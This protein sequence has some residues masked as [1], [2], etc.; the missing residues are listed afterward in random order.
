[1][2]NIDKLEKA[3]CTGC[4][5]CYNICPVGAISLQDNIEGFR[6]PVINKEKC[7]NCGLCAKVCPVLNPKYENNK[8]PAC[9]AFMADDEIR[10][11]SSSGGAFI[12]LAYEFLNNGGYVAGAVWT[13]DY[14]VKHIVSNKKEDV[15][16]MRKSKYLQSDIGDCYTQIKSI[17][18]KDKKVLFTGTPCQV[19][20]LKS[21]LR[22]D[23]ENLFCVDLICHGVPSPKVFKKYIEEE[24][25]S[26]QDEKWISTDFRDKKYGWGSGFTTTTTTTTTIKTTVES[27][28]DNTFMKSF[29]A[30]VCLRKSCSSCVVSKIPR[31]GDITIGDLWTIKKDKKYR[32][33]YCDAKGTS[34]VLCNSKKGKLLVKTLSN[35]AKLLN[36]IPLKKAFLG[37]PNIKKPTIAHINREVFFTNIDNMRLDENVARNLEDKCDCM[38]LNFWSAVNYGAILTCYGI[39]CLLEKLGYYP[40]IINYIGYPKSVGC[41]DFEKSFSNKFAQK[42]FNLTKEVN[43]YEDFY[44]LN[45][46]CDTFITGSDQVWRKGCAQGVLNENLNWTLF[47]LDFVR[48]DKKKLSYAASIGTNNIDGT[49]SDYE[50][51]NYYLSQFDSISV[52]EEKGKEL[53]K[54]NFDIESTQIVD[55]IFHIPIETL[56]K[57]T[58][59]YQVNEKYIGC[60]LLPYFIGQKWSKNILDTVSKKL[61]L[62]I[63][64][65]KFDYQ[66]PVEEWLAFIK[67]SQFIITDSYHGTLTSIIFNVPFL[68][69]QNA[70]HVQSRFDTIFNSF[71]I[72][73]KSISQFDETLNYDELLSPFDWIKINNNIKQEVERAECWVKHA[74][75]KE[76][77][78]KII[79]PNFIEEIQ[80]NTL[81]LINKDKI[82]RQYYK[83]KILSKI[84]FGKKRKYYKQKRILLKNKLRKI[85]ELQN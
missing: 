53:L 43:A 11:K 45:K 81:I 19:A 68:H 63:K 64:F 39:Q 40:K 26:E 12:V 58:E 31:Q 70:P 49:Q 4:C 61:N 55:G 38:I 51:I 52:R 56:N 67:N 65:F 76:K 3:N 71:E 29:F 21:Y 9:Y 60:F 82:L 47:Y 73:N 14:R 84:L 25:L 35:G 28:N 37:N 79:C 62:P 74:M 30:D 72:T 5:A 69:I 7:T 13:E 50:K 6:E 78:N 18:Y 1:M 83:A 42:Y 66:T 41:K 44:S 80:S 46:N 32:N 15:E 23:Y 54:E 77:K 10:A 24:K 8:K 85:R 34:L 57:M 17:L 20:G 2:D 48:S 27:A 59:E 16:K 75:I 22:K 36:N 33:K